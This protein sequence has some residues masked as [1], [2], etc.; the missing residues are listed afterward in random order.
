M[1]QRRMFNDLITLSDSFLDMPAECQLLYFHLGMHAD[2][3]G[4]VSNTKMVQR[5]IG[6]SDDII[7]ILVL[8]KF[9]IRFDTGVCVIKHWRINNQLRKD[10]YKETKYLHEKSLLFI[11][12]NGAY[13]TNP[14]NAVQI[15][16]GHFITSETTDNIS[17]NQLAT[18]GKP[19]IGKVRLGKVRIDNTNDHYSDDRF[20]F[21]WKEYPNKVGKGKAWQAWLKLKPTN[22][23][24]R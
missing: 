4:F 1:A 11:R 18:I 13:T 16:R 23:V 21:F 14:E 7:M 8:K 5:I 15:P 19:S 20:L 6:V 10:R 9:L 24:A 17:G 22:E 3:D 2:D 12:E